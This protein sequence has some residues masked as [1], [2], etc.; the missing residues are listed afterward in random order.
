MTIEIV[1]NEN[2]GVLIIINMSVAS[3]LTDSLIKA[4]N[5]NIHVL[6]EWEK[7]FIL[8]IQIAARHLQ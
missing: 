1:F 7:A 5:Y 3:N 6:F 4:Q 8:N 2:C